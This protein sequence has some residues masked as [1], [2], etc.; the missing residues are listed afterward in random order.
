[1]SWS[2]LNLSTTTALLNTI[3]EEIVNGPGTTN[4]HKN[5][6]TTTGGNDQLQG[7]SV[8]QTRRRPGPA[9]VSPRLGDVKQ[10]TTLRVEFYFEDVTD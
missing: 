9:Q 8:G 10:K 1:M 5:T 6:T 7:A 2:K 3:G 4:N